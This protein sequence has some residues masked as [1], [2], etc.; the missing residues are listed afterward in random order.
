M[1][2]VPAGLTELGVTRGS[3][4]RR[5]SREFLGPARELLHLVR[6]RKRCYRHRPNTIDKNGPPNGWAAATPRPTS[7]QSP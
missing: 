2:G 5:A 1:F 4:G 7:G 6:E 3:R